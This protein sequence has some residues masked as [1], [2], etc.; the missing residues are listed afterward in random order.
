MKPGSTDCAADALTTI[1]LRRYFHNYKNKVF[2][3]RPILQFGAAPFVFTFV[4]LRVGYW[5]A[6]FA[7]FLT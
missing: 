2:S 6:L 7:L 3:G 5:A 4:I 1:S